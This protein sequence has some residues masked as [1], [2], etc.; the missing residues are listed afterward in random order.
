[1]YRYSRNANGLRESRTNALLLLN[2]CAHVPQVHRGYLLRE[3]FC[4]EPQQ[5][6]MLEAVISKNKSLGFKSED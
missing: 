3:R 4:A 2:E 6:R 5:Q 1:M